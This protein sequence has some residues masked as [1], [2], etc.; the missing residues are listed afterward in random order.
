[1]TVVARWQIGMVTAD[2]RTKENSART[3]KDCGYPDEVSVEDVVDELEE[4]LVKEE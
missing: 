1:M 3:H 4:Q 2:G